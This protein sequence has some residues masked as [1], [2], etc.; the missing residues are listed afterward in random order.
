M[1]YKWWVERGEDLEHQKLGTFY[2]SRTE[3]QIGRKKKN[4]PREIKFDDQREKGSQK[5]INFPEMGR[6]YRWG[7]N[8][9]GKSI[10]GFSQPPAVCEITNNVSQT[11]NVSISSAERWHVAV[12]LFIKWGFVCSI[13]LR[14]TTLKISLWDRIQVR[15]IKD[16]FK[17]HIICTRHEAL[18]WPKI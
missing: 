12:I 8:R 13:L 1:G 10:F 18:R 3:T 7:K 6:I 9:R 16:M 4:N 5:P 15:E 11:P 14:M 2:K 17:V